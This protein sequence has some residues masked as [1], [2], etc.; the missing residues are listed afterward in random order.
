M[1]QVESMALK[2]NMEAFHLHKAVLL[3]MIVMG[4]G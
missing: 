3:A 1:W 2:I 4:D